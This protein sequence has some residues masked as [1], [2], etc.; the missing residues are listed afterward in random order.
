MKQINVLLDKPY[1]NFNHKKSNYFYYIL[2][3]RSNITI[4][5]QYDCETFLSFKVYE[6]S[7]GVLVYLRSGEIALQC[8]IR[9]NTYTLTPSHMALMTNRECH[10]LF[11]YLGVDGSQF[12]QS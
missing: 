10:E 5:I 1:F 2:Q 7:H 12:F 11:S 8:Q 6:V 3:Q 4:F 9:G